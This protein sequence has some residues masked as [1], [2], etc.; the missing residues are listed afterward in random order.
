MTSGCWASLKDNAENPS[1]L[2]FTIQF[3]GKNIKNNGLK[4]SQVWHPKTSPDALRLSGPCD[5]AP[6]VAPVTSGVC[7]AWK[8]A[9]TWAV[10]VSRATP[11][12]TV[13]YDILAQNS[14]KCPIYQTLSNL[15]LIP[16]DFVCTALVSPDSPRL[17][18]QWTALTAS[19][20][21]PQLT[22]LRSIV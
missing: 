17:V 13:I 19:E 18:V 1:C 4:V 7:K 22:W 3:F 14:N 10:T 21:R 9:F 20:T 16:S 11:E 12:P 15:T 8:F 5:S 2:M 6:G